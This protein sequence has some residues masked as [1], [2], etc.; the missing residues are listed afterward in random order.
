MTASRPPSSGVCGARR[1]S[2][3]LDPAR[4][5]LGL[6]DANSSRPSSSTRRSHA[7]RRSMRIVVWWESRPIGWGTRDPEVMLFRERIVPPREDRPAMTSR[8]VAL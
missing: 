2:R 5:C 8:K 6:C 3:L 4:L 7:R 1:R